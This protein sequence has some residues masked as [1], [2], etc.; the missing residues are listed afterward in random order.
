[1]T[2]LNVA[3]EYLSLLRESES[4]A[5]ELGSGIRRLEDKIRSSLSDLA[6]GP[7]GE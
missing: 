7:G 2:A 1:M 4:R 6:S 5:S 3:H